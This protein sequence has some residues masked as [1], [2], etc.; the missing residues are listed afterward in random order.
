MRSITGALCAAA[1]ALALAA[2]ADAD[3]PGDGAGLAGT[4][5]AE[6]DIPAEGVPSRSWT[7]DELMEQAKEAK[8]AIEA[9]R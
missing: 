6:L 7:E 1:F 8:A 3:A 5:V 9:G 4:W 2:C